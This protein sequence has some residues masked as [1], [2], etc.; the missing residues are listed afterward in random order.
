MQSDI[1][2]YDSNIQSKTPGPADEP[3]Q[4]EA[5]HGHRPDG[6]HPPSYNV[7]SNLG[8]D[9]SA[10]L[11]AS[12][13]QRTLVPHILVLFDGN[14]VSGADGADVAAQ[15]WG[16][17]GVSRM[18][19]ALFTNALFQA[20]ICD[21][22]SAPPQRGMFKKNPERKAFWQKHAFLKKHFDAHHRL[23]GTFARNSGGVDAAGP[24]RLQAGGWPEMM[25][26][27][28]EIHVQYE[29]PTGY[30]F[31]RRGVD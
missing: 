8:P 19:Y 10:D 18:G 28:V 29:P 6:E 30:S 3:N 2:A 26:N 22:R 15:A 23:L 14:D 4:T 16:R 5:D 20:Y 27:V 21:R 9:H 1:A 11:L 17:E 25:R 24:V 13:K 7:L 31:K 12:V